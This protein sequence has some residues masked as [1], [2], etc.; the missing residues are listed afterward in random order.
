MSVPKVTYL[1][2]LISHGQTDAYAT[3]KGSVYARVNIISNQ[4][5]RIAC[6]YFDNREKIAAFLQLFETY[7]K[8]ATVVYRSQSAGQV[9]SGNYVFPEEVVGTLSNFSFANNW[10]VGDLTLTN[11]DVSELPCYVYIGIAYRTEHEQIRDL[12]FYL[13]ESEPTHYVQVDPILAFHS[14]FHEFEGISTSNDAMFLSYEL[15]HSLKRGEVI[16]PLYEA[17]ASNIVPNIHLNVTHI[18]AYYD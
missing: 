16:D 8:P 13:H 15:L 9:A 6:R 7:D 2:V 18:G 14:R 3:V 11:H 5:V 17:A 10:L 1:P 4:Q 12:C